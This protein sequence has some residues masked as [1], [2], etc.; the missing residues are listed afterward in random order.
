MI[1]INYLILAALVVYL[2]I[3][4][5]FYVDELDRKTNISGAFIGGVV[6]A[7]VTS[8]PEFFTSFTAVLKFNQPNL[9]QGNILGSNLFNLTI[10]G[11][12]ILFSAKQFKEAKI[13]KSHKNNLLFGLLMFVLVL[14]GFKLDFL[15]VTIGGFSFSFVSVIILV[16]YI[17]SVKFMSDDH[18]AMNE[19]EPQ[20]PLTVKQVFIRFGLFAIMLI[21]VSV[22]LTQ[23]TDRI[24]TDL[25][26]GA[27][28]AGA[29]FLGVATSLP[30]LTSC[31][32]LVRMRNY[33]A[34]IG[35]VV[36]S[37]IFNFAI[38]AVSDFVFT[39]GSIFVNDPQALRL[40]SFGVISTLATIL[41][42]NLKHKTLWTRMISIFLLVVYAISVL[43]GL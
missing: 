33:N 16:L 2:S 19:E 43:I 23:T 10:L 13:S 32:S 17:L 34:A 41:L 21:I 38:F 42:M 5:S 37:N 27:T 8:L 18:S 20:T 35:N 9:V 22:M 30:E 25:N 4:L 11:V 14:A 24:A 6:L 12:L 31:I 39:N 7:A 29:I 15:V 3:K 36:G 28:A 1:Y 26:L 40:V